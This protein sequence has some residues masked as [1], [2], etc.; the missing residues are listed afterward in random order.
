M[1]RTLRLADLRASCDRLLAS[2]EARF[3]AEVD[4]DANAVADY[5]AVDVRSAYSLCPSPE[6]SAGDVTDDLAEIQNLLQGPDDEVVLWHDI[7]HLTGLL[8][9]LA[10]LDLPSE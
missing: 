2:A 5:W 3:G 9:A 4:L 1:A 6:F 7:D 8:R 10:Y